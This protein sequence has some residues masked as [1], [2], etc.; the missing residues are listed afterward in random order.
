M[1][2]EWKTIRNG[3]LWSSYNRVAG[4]KVKM[5]DRTA[6]PPLLEEKNKNTT[7][8]LISDLFGIPGASCHHRSAFSGPTHEL[9][10]G[11]MS[12]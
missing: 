4:E 8:F 3:K 1:S 9:H 11:Y 10:T 7:K 12:P 5:N 6:F 2:A